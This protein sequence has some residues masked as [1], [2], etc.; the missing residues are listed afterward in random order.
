MEL[1]QP[2][3]TLSIRSWKYAGAW[4]N[5]NGV[6]LKCLF[7]MGTTNADLALESLVRLLW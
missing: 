2:I 4:L 1:Q 5:P 6:C 3:N 7:P